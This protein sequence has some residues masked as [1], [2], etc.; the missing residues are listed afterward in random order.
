[1]NVLESRAPET[2]PVGASGVG[3]A[4]NSAANSLTALC[5]LCEPEP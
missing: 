4:R 3:L 1:M 2:A 5:L